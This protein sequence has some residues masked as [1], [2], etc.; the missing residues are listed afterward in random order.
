MKN[1]ELLICSCHSTEHQYIFLYEDEPY[2]DGKIDRSVYI[3]THLNTY[4]FWKRLIKGVR[5]IFGYHCKYGHFDEFI[6]NPEDVGKFE[7]VVNFLK[8]EEYQKNVE[9]LNKDLDEEMSNY[10]DAEIIKK[11]EDLPVYINGKLQ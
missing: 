4:P 6:I 5:Y 9:D 8:G 7:K 2:S 1:K 11:Y 10:V 3:H